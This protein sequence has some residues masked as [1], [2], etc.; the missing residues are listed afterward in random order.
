MV[1]NEICRNYIAQKPA[2]SLSRY[3]SGQK[4]C[5]LCEVFVNWQGIRCSCCGS[6]LRTKPRNQIQKKAPIARVAPIK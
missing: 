3:A 4:R 1:C 5:Q 2:P 6:E